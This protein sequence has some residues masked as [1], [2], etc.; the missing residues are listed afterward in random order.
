M[1]KSKV[2]VLMSTYNGKKYVVEQIDSILAQ[3]YK[4]IYLYVRDDGSTDGTVDILRKYEKEGKLQIITGENLGFCKSFM[5]LLRIVSD[6]EYWAFADQDDIWHPEKIEHSI[7]WLSKQNNNRPLLY[8]CAYECVDERLNHLYECKPRTPEFSF[9]RCMTENV[10]TGCV[11][12]INKSMRDHMLGFDLNRLDYHDWLAG[13]IAHAFGT[14][15]FD[16][17][18]LAK[19]RRLDESISRATLKKNMTWFFSSFKKPSNMKIRN[20]AFYDSYADEFDKNSYD[21]KILKMFAQGSF[22]NAIKKA[23]FPHRWRYSFVGEAA[24]R[25]VMLFGKL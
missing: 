15:M 12:T 7:A 1:I 11:M 19:H 4:N 21:F 14:A 17:L 9:R 5:E 10:Y 22:V 18:I 24:V 16:D 25:I 13:A 8:Q 23:F 3:T 20:R 2:N 6:G